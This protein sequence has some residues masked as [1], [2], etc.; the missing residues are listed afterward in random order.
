MQKRY[1]VALVVGV[2]SVISAVVPSLASGET[3][4]NARD[5]TAIYTDPPAAL[6]GGYSLLTDAAGLACID[7]PGQG[8]MGVHYVNGTLIQSGALDPARPQAL[9]YEVRPNGGLQLAAV[10]YVV[11]Q[12]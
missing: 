12:S 2:V 7:M 1:I 11:F 4:A 8:A 9:V 10:E 6:A 5:A 3:L